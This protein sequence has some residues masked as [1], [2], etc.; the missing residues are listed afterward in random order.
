VRADPASWRD[1]SYRWFSRK[2][3]NRALLV[4]TRE[5]SFEV[6]F[7]DPWGPPPERPLPAGVEATARV[8]AEELRI[9]T[10][11]PGHPLLVKVSYHPR[12]RA[13]G[14]DGPYLVSPGLMLIV[15]RER[16]VRLH[17]AA[18]TWADRL[19]RTAFLAAIAAGVVLWRRKPGRTAAGP[20]ASVR[21]PG[22]RLER[23]GRLQLV[24]PRVLP[25]AIVAGLAALRFAPAPRPTVDVTRLDEDASRAFA[26]E[27]FEA[28]AE[29][30]RNAL[31][32]LGPED[33]RRS[34]LL[35]LRGE[36]LLRTGHPRIAVLA[37]APVVE[38]G[39]GPYRPQA[40]YSGAL[41]RE[42]VGDAA[43]AAAWR[44]SLLAD[45]PRTPWAER[46]AKA[47]EP[48]QSR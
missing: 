18:R 16:E 23:A 25:L 26:E 1:A 35:C 42:A 7:D 32:A 8:E 11:R 36:A 9:T 22:V 45:H 46:L 4:F 3:A 37:F 39:S 13:E 38:A 2:P 19:G 20:A 14:A 48:P 34:E 12:W 17:Y 43:G 15:P 27:R 24:L 44:A 29:Y 31:D 6:A 5:R 40:L 47:L 21:G 33:A 30:A 41:A 28:A 10:S